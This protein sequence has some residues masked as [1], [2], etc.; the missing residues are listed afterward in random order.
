MSCLHLAT[1]DLPHTSREEDGSL[2]EAVV[3]LM[4]KHKSEAPTDGNPRGWHPQKIAEKVKAS[5]I[6][7]TLLFLLSE[8]SKA[9]GRDC[10]MLSCVGELLQDNSEAKR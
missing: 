10:I 7:T 2:S 9:N 1:L 6:G 5:I 4:A 8:P 3:E